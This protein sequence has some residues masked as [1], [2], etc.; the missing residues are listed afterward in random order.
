MTFNTLAARTALLHGPTRPWIIACIV[1]IIM[2]M[3]FIALSLVLCV[4]GIQMSRHAWE[5]GV[6]IR[7]NR[8]ERPRWLHSRA[9][10]Q[11]LQAKQVV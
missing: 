9:E 11:T 7:D 1:L 6:N 4:D 3:G 8:R 5:R 10:R 2:L